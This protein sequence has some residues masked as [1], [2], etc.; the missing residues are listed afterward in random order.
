MLI[1]IITMYRGHDAEMFVH[2]VKG[3]LTA[4]QRDAWRKAHYCDDHF[5]G[6]FEGDEDDM[7]N[8]FFRTLTL[9]E[10][11]EPCTIL[12]A[13]GEVSEQKLTQIPAV[14]VDCIGFDVWGPKTD[15]G[16][17]A[18]GGSI[19]V[20]NDTNVDIQ[21]ECHDEPDCY[22]DVMDAVGQVFGLVDRDHWPDSLVEMFQNHIAPGSEFQVGLDGDRLVFL[23][24]GDELTSHPLPTQ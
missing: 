22:N 20:S 10:V 13:D 23:P 14:K 17:Y 7:N 15:D 21:I 1:T 4:E 6:R 8:M 9:D 12:T 2:A 16:P 19:H 18:V 11:G 3:T 24:V 5:E